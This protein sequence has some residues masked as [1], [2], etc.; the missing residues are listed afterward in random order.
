VSALRGPRR[1]LY[2]RTP[3]AEFARLRGGDV[4]EVSMARGQ[5]ER[6]SD[7]RPVSGG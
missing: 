7:H 2:G 3:F 1:I 6:P 4:A 5:D